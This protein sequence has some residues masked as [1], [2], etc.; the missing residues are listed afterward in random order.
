M[1]RVM[2]VGI[3][4]LS[5]ASFAENYSDLGISTPEG[6]NDFRNDPS[7]SYSRQYSSDRNTRSIDYYQY[8]RSYSQGER[9]RPFDFSMMEHFNDF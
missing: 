6:D 7:Y 4:L 9:Q 5:A 8:S 2:F 3:L 1:R